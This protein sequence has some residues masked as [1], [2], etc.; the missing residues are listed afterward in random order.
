MSLESTAETTDFD[1]V[2]LRSLSADVARAVEAAGPTNEDDVAAAFTKL[3]GIAVPKS[4]ARLLS[5]FTWSARGRGLIAETAEG[6]GV[7]QRAA[8]PLSDNDAFGEESFASIQLVVDAV[9]PDRN[10][11]FALLCDTVVQFLLDRGCKDAR[12]LRSTVG[13][14]VWATGRRSPRT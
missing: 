11:E 3:T 4:R 2:P 5:R 1:A 14:A 13:S 7:L 6:S 9:D 12:L 8:N 10:T